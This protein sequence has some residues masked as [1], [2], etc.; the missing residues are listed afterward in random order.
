MNDLTFFFCCGI[1]YFI[2]Y[3][4]FY[5][6]ANAERV[7]DGRGGAADRR[8][9]EE[10]SPDQG[11]IEPGLQHNR[12]RPHGAGQVDDQEDRVHDDLKVI[13]SLTLLKI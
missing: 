6:P 12:Q 9:G 10:Q 5:L 11:R 3:Y 4:L 8:D 7:V 13:S 2:N 1:H